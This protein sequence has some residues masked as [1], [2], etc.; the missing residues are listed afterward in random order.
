MCCTSLGHDCDSQEVAE[1]DV[2]DVDIAVAAARRAFDEGPW[3][4]MSG[5]VC[6]LHPDLVTKTSQ[7]TFIQ[8]L[9]MLSCSVALNSQFKSLPQCQC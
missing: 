6:A 7:S 9:F 8:Y 2:A 3:P 5:A 1:A 4:K